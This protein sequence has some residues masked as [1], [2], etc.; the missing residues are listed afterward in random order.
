MENTVTLAI[1]QAR[2]GSTRLPGKVMREV[3]GKPLITH[4]LQRLKQCKKI[5]NIVV[6]MPED[7]SNDGLCAV[8]ER[9]GFEVFRGSEDDVLD[10]FYQASVRYPAATIVRLTADCPLIDPQVVDQTIELHEKNGL[11]YAATASDAPGYPDGLDT[12]V[13]SFETL[14]LAWQ[15]SRLSSEREHV[16]SYM[17]HSDR[18]KKMVL[19]PDKD[20]SRERWT[21]DQEEDFLLVKAIFEGLYP[22]NT[23]FGMQDVLQFKAAHP[24]MF[25]ING[26]IARNEGYE[27]SLR[28]DVEK[29]LVSVVMAVYNGER[30]LAEQLESLLSQSHRHLEII[31]LDDAS[32]DRSL[33]IVK[34]VMAKD[35][36]IQIHQNMKNM[37]QVAAFLKGMSLVRGEFIC[38]S[39][40]DDVWKPEKIER[41]K[42]L[43]EK[44]PKNILVYSD[45]EVCDEQMRGVN[46]SFW[47]KGKLSPQRGDLSNR[48]IL[49]NVA[50]GFSMMFHRKLGN[51]LADV[52]RDETFRRLN[53]GP[54]LDDLPFNHDHLA[55]TLASFIGRIDYMP[56]ALACY[57]QHD[58]NVIGPSYKATKEEGHFIRILEKKIELLKAVP[59]LQPIAKTGPAERFLKSLKNGSFME[60]ISLLPYY[61]YVRNAS[62]LQKGLG[63]IQCFFP[64]LY[65]R[66]RQWQRQ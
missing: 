43:L 1:V 15:N 20:Y 51:L 11:D 37:G 5:D 58:R 40:Q 63:A 35:P 55:F 12:E 48:A 54:R 27:K 36:R 46:S 38:F 60:R 33:S 41:L 44:N 3:L 9:Q 18:F 13:F 31:V 64:R 59:C 53:V 39:D 7:A 57:R 26:A 28:Q 49:K 29:G 25:E 61:L 19:R 32:T 47:K 66:L 34:E 56:R 17:I 8:V 65:T 10:R 2:M 50:P 52:Y 42:N 30:Y 6:A 45:V 23:G 21:V 4:M 24:K 14:R 22:D 16:T 62:V